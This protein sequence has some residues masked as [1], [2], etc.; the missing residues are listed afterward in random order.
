[1]EP[2]EGVSTDKI[3]K[4]AGSTF[5]GKVISTG[6]KYLTDLT[7]AWL[8][9]AEL[10]GLYT[11]G[12][13][14]Y[15]FGE[16]FS[17]MGLESGAIR[18][19][20]IHH[21]ENNLQRL[22][23][24]LLHSLFLS[25]VSGFVFGGLLFIS[26]E[27]IAQKLFDEPELAPVLRVFALALPFG[28]GTTVGAFATTG[29]KI[30]KYRTYAWELILPLLNLVLALVL[31]ALG[32]GLL[33]TAFAWLGATVVSFFV[34]LHFI[35]IIFPDVVDP[36]LKPLF[37][38]RQLL[39]FS[40][41]LAF[42]SFAWLVLLWTDV[43]MLG[44]FRPA[45]EVGIYRAASQTSLLMN[46]VSS[47]LIV[48]FAPM[49]ADFYSRGER[50]E[51]QNIFQTSSRWSFALTLPLFLIM[52]VV[53]DDVLR[54]FG[55]EFTV[56]W[57]PLIILCAGQLARAGAG[58]M[59]IQVLSMT[60]HQYL[61]LYTDLGLAGVN[62][63]LNIVLIPQWGALGAAIATGISITLVNLLRATLMNHVLGIGVQVYT[64]TYF[65]VLM[66]GTIATF[67]GLGFRLGL[68]PIHFFWSAL[69]I[70]T[71]IMLTY[72]GC[73]RGMGLD[74]SDQVVV[75]KMFKKLKPGRMK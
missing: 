47:S 60:G 66:A 71:I 29:F 30:T 27:M 21:G 68:P 24:T 72:A 34:T 63:F 11:L 41:P 2:T 54:I 58:G 17:R 15:R 35:R 64:M 12:I 75:N 53:G 38:G 67:V 69:L 65:K 25:L 33:G 31:Y 36:K 44:Y 70:S 7:F 37:N 28:T 6:I 50:Q 4:G 56:G 22:K 32:F 14:I 39:G 1:M 19:I 51:V 49:V 5:I 26:A 59:A 46:L 9:G 48:S 40:I 20:A 13:V 10:F 16:L 61:K 42:G 43:L 52:V 3:A 74:Q 57:I 45:A 62:I 18:Y 73:L 23:G 8:L 55:S